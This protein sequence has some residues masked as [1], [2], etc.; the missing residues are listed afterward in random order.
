MRSIY[1]EHMVEFSEMQAVELWYADLEAE[2]LIANIKDVEIRG[3][4]RKGLAKGRERS[5]LEYDFPKLAQTVGEAVLIKDSPPT[6]Y[7][8]RERGKNEFGEVVPDAF[9]RY[10]TSLPRRGVYS[11]TDFIS[12]T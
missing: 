7:H 2:K 11:L 4:A 3:R 6:I 12:G 1:R 8:W 5:V 10:R 9:A